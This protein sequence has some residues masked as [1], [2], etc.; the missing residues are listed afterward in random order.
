MIKILLISTI[1]ALIRAT[2]DRY[3][4][5]GGWKTWAFIEGA[6]V[7][8]VVSYLIGGAWYEIGLG[9]LLFGFT[10]WIVFDC[11]TGIYFGRHPLYIGNTG[12]DKKI[13]AIFQYTDRWKG[14]WY[15]MVK[16]IWWWFAFYLYTL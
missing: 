12:F 4:R 15:L 14:T 1:Y 9:A 2:H 7:A 8:V 3:L 5:Q 16:L 6:F 11:M 13:R 10:F